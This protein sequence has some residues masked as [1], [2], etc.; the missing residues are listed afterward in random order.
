MN[1]WAV[2]YVGMRHEAGGR[3]P[4]AVDC[5]GLLVLAYREVWGIELP[6]FP[7]LF[8]NSI[9]DFSRVLE[10]ERGNWTKQPIPFEGAAVAMGRGGR[11]YHVGLFVPCPGWRVLHSWDRQR[12]VLD[13]M[14]ALKLKGLS[15]VEFYQHKLWTLPT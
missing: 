15:T 2:K 8:I 13:S 7:G 3:G 12:V 11:V 6:D 5:W 10:Q 1:H 4:Q 9:Q 14:R